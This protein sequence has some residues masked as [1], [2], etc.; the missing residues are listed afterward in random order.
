MDHEKKGA[1]GDRM[2]CHHQHLQQQQQQAGGGSQEKL[3]EEDEGEDHLEAERQ[4][5]AIME[6]LHSITSEMSQ[7]DLLVQDFGKEFLDWWTLHLPF[8]EVYESNEALIDEI[9]EKIVASINRVKE[10]VSNLQQQV[11]HLAWTDCLEPIKQNLEGIN[12]FV[13]RVTRKVEISGLVQQEDAPADCGKLLETIAY[14]IK[15]DSEEAAFSA[16]VKCAH[17]QHTQGE[18]L[19]LDLLY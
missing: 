11:A 4:L 15:K 9:K 10:R 7:A 8:P 19:L 12:S 13:E 17:T 5:D 16:E 18:V 1:T 14:G 2:T 6:E 3:I